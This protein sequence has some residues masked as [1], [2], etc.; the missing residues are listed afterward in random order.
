MLKRCSL[1]IHF[2]FPIRISFT[3]KAERTLNVKLICR[4]QHRL[5]PLTLNV[6]AEGFTVAA[7]VWLE[8]IGEGVSNLELTP[9]WSPCIGTGDP[10]R[11]AEDAANRL[12]DH[13]KYQTKMNLLD[14]GTVQPGDCISR[15]LT[16]VNS[17]KFQCDFSLRFIS[18]C[19]PSLRASNHFNLLVNGDDEQNFG[20]IV[21]VDRATGSISPGETAQCSVI[22][23]PPKNVRAFPGGQVKL[24]EHFLACLLSI[25]EGPAYGLAL[26][27][28][29]SGQT[30]YFSPEIVDFGPQILATKGLTSARR[31]LTVRNTDAKRPVSFECLTPNCAVFKQSLEPTILQPRSSASEDVLGSDT[32][33]IEITFAPQACQKYEKQLIFEMNGSIQQAILLLGEGTDLLVDSKPG[34]LTIISINQPSSPD[35]VLRILPVVDANVL[36]RPIYMGNLQPSQRSRRFVMLTNRSSAPILVHRVSLNEAGNGSASVSRTASSLID[37]KTTVNAQTGAY[38]ATSVRLC[39]PISDDHQTS[40]APVSQVTAP[41]MMKPKNGQIMVEVTFAPSR[42][43]ASFTREVLCEISAC[44][45]E[46]LTNE[47]KRPYSDREPKFYLPVFSVQGACRTYDIQ[48]DRSSV[49]FGPVVQGSQ[50]TKSLNLL[51]RGDLGSK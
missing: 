48:F 3:A 19:K 1:P 43:L 5:L 24:T 33:R 26:A 14:F 35:R 31:Y 10:S 29:T 30:V 2:R 15:K 51:N 34:P 8:D 32:M 40:L 6:K 42:R 23:S 28:S 13:P 49:N 9:L 22:F 7:S 18:L 38:S 39:M 45:R 46:D 21:R 12:V 17:G 27:G 16:I 41:V 44:D 50:L 25:R 47:S 4:V 37:S 20:A 36:D 11:Y